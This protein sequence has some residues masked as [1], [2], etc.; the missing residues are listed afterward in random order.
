[1]RFLQNKLPNKNNRPN[2]S[3]FS[4]LKLDKSMGLSL[5]GHLRLGLERGTKVA[6]KPPYTS[7]RM[8]TDLF[9]SVTAPSKP[10]LGVLGNIG[11]FRL[12]LLH[13]TPRQG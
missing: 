3:G 13:S 6:F 2:P 11:K 12:S 5:E 8:F 4:A 1:M 9:L 10:S 7:N